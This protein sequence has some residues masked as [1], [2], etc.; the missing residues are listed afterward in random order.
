MRSGK[1]SSYICENIIG[2]SKSSPNIWGFSLAGNICAYFIK[3]NATMSDIT[4]F[5]SK[6]IIGNFS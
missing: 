3:K 4:K 5:N 6:K 1:L 2:K